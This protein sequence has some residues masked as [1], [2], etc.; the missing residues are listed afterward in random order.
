MTMC[1][2]APGVYWST[3]IVSVGIQSSHGQ[4]LATDFLEIGMDSVPLDVTTQFGTLD[5]HS[6]TLP[7][8]LLCDKH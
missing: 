1:N 2:E 8:W 5:S 4:Q 3:C 7:V 6:S